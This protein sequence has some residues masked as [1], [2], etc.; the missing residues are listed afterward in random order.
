MINIFG[1]IIKIENINFFGKPSFN[2]RD[3]K[4]HVKIKDL[5]AKQIRCDKIG[6][7]YLFPDFEFE[8]TQIYQE[9]AQLVLKTMRRLIREFPCNKESEVS[10]LAQNFGIANTSNN[11][12][13]YRELLNMELNIHNYKDS[14]IFVLGLRSIS[15]ILRWNIKT[16]SL[17][18][19]NE[20]INDVKPIV[21]NFNRKELLYN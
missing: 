21:I 20:V 4:A 19:I 1:S 3:N 13:F 2:R 9:K 7:L 14:S 8:T 17:E 18:T 10:Y 12:A 6:A 11:E 5:L 15:A 16:I